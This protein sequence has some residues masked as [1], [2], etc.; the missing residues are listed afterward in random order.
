MP[1]KIEQLVLPGPELQVAPVTDKTPVIIRIDAVYPHGTAFRYDLV[2]Y[3]LEAGEYDLRKYLKRKDGSATDDLPSLAFQVASLL[4]SGQ[5]EPHEPSA[6]VLPWMGGYRVIAASVATLWFIGLL[7]LTFPRRRRRV[8][9]AAATAPALSL[10]DRLR[11]LVVDAMAGKLPPARLAE[12]ER[13]L[14]TYWRRRLGLEELAPADAVAQLRAHPEASPL[15]TQLET[16]LHRPA[17]SE[18]V[19]VGRLLAPYR[20]V[21]PDAF[22]AGPARSP[23]AQPQGA[24]Q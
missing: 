19:D 9:A 3:G 24:A 5:I 21:A 12:L 1:V 7:W 10:A 22:E 15:V 4:P 11:P 6:G 16:W 8:Q 13:A 14:V 2:V 20:N 17:G 23:L 18:Q